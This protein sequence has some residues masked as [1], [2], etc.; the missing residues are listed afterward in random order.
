[1]TR[2]E[3]RYTWSGD[4]SIAY[5]V[6]G[7][8]PVDLVYLP[9]V[10]SNVVLNWEL[11]EHARFMHRL[12]SFSRLIVMDR[13]GVGCSDRLPP[14]EAPQL[15]AMVDDV[16]AVMAAS[17]SP[18][19]ALYGGGKNAFT[20]MLAAASY[21]E[22]VQRLVLFSAAPT[23]IR[24]DEL[25]WQAS[26]EDVQQELRMFQRMVSLD[27]WA[28]TWVRNYAQSL[29]G[30]ARALSWFAACAAVTAG[31]GAWMAEVDVLS[32]V[33]LR[34]LLSAIRVPTLILHRTLDPTEPIESARYL[35]ERIPNATLVELP[36]EDALPWLG[37]Q[38]AV[39]DAI[40]EFLTGTRPVP[41]SDRA[42]V[43]VLVTDIVGSTDR[44]AALGDRAWTC[45][46]ARPAQVVP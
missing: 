30:D 7:D 31:A 21:P 16:L 44:A 12:A 19:A 29:I 45:K 2:P 6:V 3:T 10:V 32:R 46:P 42:L 25:P 34:E 41:V 15:E 24:S 33:D 27:E 23:W 20:A 43:T 28:G 38:D 13:R 14:G 18:L 11:A 4:Y 37:E 35:A 17:S 26:K 40:E 22:R 1:M 8:G 5:Q 39:L 9:D 36:G